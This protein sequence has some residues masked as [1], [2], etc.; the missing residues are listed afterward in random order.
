MLVAR[1][2]DTML[3]ASLARRPQGKGTCN[4]SSAPTG[5]GHSQRQLS[6]QGG[7]GVGRR[8]TRDDGDVQVVVEATRNHARS[9]RK[10]ELNPLTHVDHAYC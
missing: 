5:E 1:G 2:P 6:A 10:R 9:G 8:A 7:S 4:V 3:P